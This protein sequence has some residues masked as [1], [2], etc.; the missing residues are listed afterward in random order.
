MRR[1]RKSPTPVAE[2]VPVPPPPPSV[3]EGEKLRVVLVCAN[4]R[5]NHLMKAADLCPKYKAY[6]SVQKVT[7]TLKPGCSHERAVND[8]RNVLVC[9]ENTDP[10]DV[11]AVFIPGRAE[12]SY[13]DP[14]IIFISDGHK[15]IPLAGVLS[16]FGY[17]FESSPHTFHT[18][19]LNRLQGKEV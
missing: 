14:D 4:R 1:N 13:V 12:Y 17:V 7:L 2:P 18:D 9:S 6:A 11:V 8:L 19:R 5:M 16:N 10:H 3:P 15:E